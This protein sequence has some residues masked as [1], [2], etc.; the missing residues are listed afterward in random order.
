MRLITTHKH[1][2][3]T[4]ASA[5]IHSFRSRIRER[6]S[7]QNADAWVNRWTLYSEFHEAIPTIPLIHATEKTR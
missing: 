4:G 6:E 3:L 1:L 7:S 5:E 2:T